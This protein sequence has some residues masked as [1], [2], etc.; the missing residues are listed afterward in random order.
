MV[1]EWDTV[2][3]AAMDLL[4]SCPGA[5]STSCYDCLRTYYNQFYHEELNRKRALEILQELGRQPD[6][7]NPIEP[8]N[9]IE[10]EGEEDTNI[11]EKQLEDIVRT[12]WGYSHFDAQGRVELPDINSYTLPDLLHEDAQIAIY[13]DGPVHSQEQQKR[14]DKYLRNALKAEGWTVIEIHIEDFDNDRMMSVY[15]QRIGNEIAA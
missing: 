3:D 12:E 13:L 7:S 14:K 15:R 10:E 9:E 6:N 4:G 8:I 1:D 5:C 11:W 2:H